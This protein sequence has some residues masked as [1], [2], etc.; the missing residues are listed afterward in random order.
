MTSHPPSKP[1]AADQRE[2]LDESQRE[3]NAQQPGSYR[4]EA[5]DDKIVEVKPIDRKDSA[6]KGLDPK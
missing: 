1:P 3:A 6:I 2:A 5:T 4:P